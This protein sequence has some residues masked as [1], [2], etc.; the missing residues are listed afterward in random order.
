MLKTNDLNLGNEKLNILVIGKRQSGKSSLINALV[1]IG[2][3]SYS[4]DPTT[5]TKD[6]LEFTEVAILGN[7]NNEQNI[8]RYVTQSDIVLFVLDAVKFELGGKI[9]DVKQYLR[10]G[11]NA[12]DVF[13]VINKSDCL[14][15]KEGESKLNRWNSIKKRIKSDLNFFPTKNIHII[16]VKEVIESQERGQRDLPFSFQSLENSLR[17]LIK[18]KAEGINLKEDK[19]WKRVIS[20][21]DVEAHIS[22]AELLLA[23]YKEQCDRVTYN[24]LL[25]RLNLICQKVNDAYLNIG[26]IGNASVGKSSFINALLRCNLLK[27]GNTLGTTLAATVIEY[28][29]DYKL[30]V[31]YF[32]NRA[33]N[34]TYDSLDSM[35]RAVEQFTTNCNY[36]RSIK[37]VN[38]GLPSSTLRDGSFRI[39]DTPGLGKYEQEGDTD[40]QVTS[41]II[42][43]MA[44]ISVVLINY[45]EQLPTHFVDFLKEISIL[46]QCVFLVSKYDEGFDE[47]DDDEDS[48]GAE[49]TIRDISYRIKKSLN[50]ENPQVLP[51]S[52]KHVKQLF[53]NNSKKKASPELVKI[54]LESEKR[55]LA[56][57][58]EYRA[59]AQTKKLISLIDNMFSEFAKFA[60][61]LKSIPAFKG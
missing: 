32:D 45:T 10:G 30:S 5:T 9:E 13:F 17:T 18:K 27:A 42:N 23:E 16:C 60:P 4:L 25:E 41:R 14:E 48:D 1:G 46:E 7:S 33:Q 53:V 11:V 47:E 15:L 3:R 34:W 49:D 51:Y 22:F 57:A 61:Y 21:D 38:I 55:I 19:S 58:S 8:Q 56:F 50:I 39:I 24:N 31:T 26:I 59:V 6:G 29:S 54:S 52:S 20:N 2:T 35:R 40:T 43:D 37:T 12:D 28:S 44:D 36:A